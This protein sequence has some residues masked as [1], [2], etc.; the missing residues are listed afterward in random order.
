MSRTWRSSA[1]AS[2]SGYPFELGEE[3]TSQKGSVFYYNSALKESTIVG[4]ASVQ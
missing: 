3:R 4:G 1:P 2:M